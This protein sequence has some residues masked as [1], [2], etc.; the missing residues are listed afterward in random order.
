[1]VF[2]ATNY[3]TLFGFYCW[4]QRDSAMTGGIDVTLKAHKWNRA[5]V[6]VRIQARFEIRLADLCDDFLQR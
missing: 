3:I 5:P 4:K 2:A 1:M 6:G